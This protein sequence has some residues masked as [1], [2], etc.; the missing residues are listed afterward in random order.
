MIWQLFFG[1]WFSGFMIG[2]ALCVYL[3]RR[4]D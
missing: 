2:F 4:Q 1:I 3:N